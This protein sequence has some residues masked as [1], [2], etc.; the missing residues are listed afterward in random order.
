M[1]LLVSII[2]LWAIWGAFRRSVS[3][4]PFTME[5]TLPLRGVLAIGIVIHHISLR[6]V[7]AIP[8]DMW[9]FPQF[10]FWGAPIVAVFFFLSGYG[11]MVSLI[12]KGENYLDGFL[13]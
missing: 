10:Q 5:A 1:V 4:T 3:L 6:V 7:D 13:K 12:T 2:F 11:L 9:I 8:G